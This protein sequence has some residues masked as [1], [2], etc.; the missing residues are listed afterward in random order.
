[1]FYSHDYYD[2]QNPEWHKELKEI[3][4]QNPDGREALPQLWFSS[5]FYFSPVPKLQYFVFLHSRHSHA[6]FKVQKVYCFNHN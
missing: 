1:M 4:P 3:Q 6:Q 2:M 5:S